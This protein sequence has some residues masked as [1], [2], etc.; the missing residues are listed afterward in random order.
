MAVAVGRGVA[1]D[2]AV[3]VR[4]KVLVGAGRFVGEFVGVQ[5][6]VAGAG[7]AEAGPFVEIAVGTTVSVGTDEPSG[8]AGLFAGGT[9]GELA[10]GGSARCADVDVGEISRVLPKVVGLELDALCVTTMASTADTAPRPTTATASNHVVRV[11]TL[12]TCQRQRP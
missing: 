1:V 2:V 11:E 10:T 6:G 9:V 12:S 3:G 7:A 8:D 5:V 4:V